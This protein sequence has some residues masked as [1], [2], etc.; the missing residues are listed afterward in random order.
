MAAEQRAGRRARKQQRHPPQRDRQ[1]ARTHHERADHPCQPSIL[2]LTWRQVHGANRRLR[3][4]ERTLTYCPRSRQ[5]LSAFLVQPA[6]SPLSHGGLDIPQNDLQA[7]VKA[8]GRVQTGSNR[9]RLDTRASAL[10][11]DQPI[12]RKMIVTPAL[13]A[14]HRLRVHAVSPHPDEVGDR[15]MLITG[16]RHLPDEAG[17][18]TVVARVDQLVEPQLVAQLTKLAHVSWVDPVVASRDEVFEGKS[19]QSERPQT[20]YEL[21]VHAVIARPHE[22]VDGEALYPLPFHAA[23]KRGIDTVIAEPHQRVDGADAIPEIRHLAEVPSGDA[24]LSAVYQLLERRARVLERVQLVEK[25]KPDVAP[26]EPPQIEGRRPGEPATHQL[27]GERGVW[28]EAERPTTGA[29]AN[30]ALEV[31]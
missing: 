10:Q 11:L 4:H 20:L 17:I 13:Q 14:L 29:R 26:R 8:P 23:D 16:G 5:L 22:I 28:R 27:V 24:V 15:W 12:N 21:R 25:T 3:F 1:V 31:E 6:I 30:D 9:R 2:S 7:L 18:H 19:R